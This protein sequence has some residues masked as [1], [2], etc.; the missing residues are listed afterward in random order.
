MT[1]SAIS[2]GLP[3]RPIGSG[4]IHS[5][6]E[7]PS[8]SRTR[9]VIGVRIAPGQAQLKRIFFAAYS[10]AAVRVNPTTPC[11]EAIKADS[12]ESGYQADTE[13]RLGASGSPLS[14]PSNPG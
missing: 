3:I 6:S 5:S 1:A 14:Q 10:W 13:R 8:L 2:S 7:I 4:A 11:L 12:D 9:S